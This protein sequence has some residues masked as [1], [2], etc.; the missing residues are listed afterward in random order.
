MHAMYVL[1][2]SDGALAGID[3]QSGGYPYPAWNV[4]EPSSLN[5]VKFY[6]NR[7]EALDYTQNFPELHVAEFS[8]S[9]T[10][11]SSSKQEDQEFLSLIKTNY[12]AGVFT[13]ESICHAICMSRTSFHRWL[14][15]KSLPHPAMRVVIVTW[16]NKLKEEKVNEASI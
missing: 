4:N 13:E 9:V 6:T 16:I 10:P 1:Q 5:G 3:W 11:V 2:Y 8:F 15:G 12:E 14:A 7:Q